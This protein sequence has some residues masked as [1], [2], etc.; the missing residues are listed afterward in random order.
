MQ[1]LFRVI[2][3]NWYGDKCLPRKC[4]RQSV[5]S[6]QSKTTFWRLIRRSLWW[7]I[8]KQFLNC[9]VFCSISYSRSQIYSKL[10]LKIQ[11]VPKRKHVCGE[12]FWT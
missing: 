5:A 11:S 7:R 10:H 6:I 4:L 8:H 12:L 1:R 2:Y 3:M 9:R